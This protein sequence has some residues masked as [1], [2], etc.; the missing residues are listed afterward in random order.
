MLTSWNLTPGIIN[1]RTIKAFKHGACG[2]LAIAIH[3]LTGWPL[4]AVTVNAGQLLHYM[5]RTPDGQLLDIEGPHTAPDVEFEYE[6]EAADGVVTITDTG[7]D[8]VWAWWCDEAGRPVPWETV[9]SIARALLDRH[10]PAAA[11]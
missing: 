4:V 2:G 5:A 1:D 11:A 6:I 7:R 9:T 10:A 8:A 3:D